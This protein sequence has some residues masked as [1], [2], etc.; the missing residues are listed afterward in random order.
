MFFWRGE[1]KRKKKKVKGAIQKEYNR[2]SSTEKIK[3]MLYQR[4]ICHSVFLQ[5][6][7]NIYLNTSTLGLT[8]T[9]HLVLLPSEVKGREVSADE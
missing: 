9:M 2:E 4:Q 7:C 8:R 3:C 5:L 6:V 1:E